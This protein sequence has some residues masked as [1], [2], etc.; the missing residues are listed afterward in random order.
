[1]GLELVDNVYGNVCDSEVQSAVLQKLACNALSFFI[2]L[3]NHNIQLCHSFFVTV[4]N[5][6]ISLVPVLRS[7]SDGTRSDLI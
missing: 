3:S 5:K 4:L 6:S 2:K 7:V 1:M